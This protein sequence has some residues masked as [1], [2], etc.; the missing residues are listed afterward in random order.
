MSTLYFFRCARCFALFG[1]V[2]EAERLSGHP[3]REL[4]EKTPCNRCQGAVVYTGIAVVQ[5]HSEW[6]RP[7]GQS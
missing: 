1:M 5:E 2:A 7:K 6:K 3:V 4:I